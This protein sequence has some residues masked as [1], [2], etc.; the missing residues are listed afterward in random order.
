MQ[1]RYPFPF[2]D[3]YEREDRDFFFGRDEEIEQLYQLT[4]QSNIVLLYGHSGTGKT[5][6]IRCGLANKFRS[7][8]WQDV[9]TP[10]HPPHPLPRPGTL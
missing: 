3:A 2:L 9:C 7:Y 5:S 10:W 8:D 1:K 4:Q 6:L